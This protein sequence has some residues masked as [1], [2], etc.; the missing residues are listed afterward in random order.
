MMTEPVT[1]YT[2]LIGVIRA[3]IGAMGVKYADFDSLA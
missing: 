1:T 3:Q 2:E